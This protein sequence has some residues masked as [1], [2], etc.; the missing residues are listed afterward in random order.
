MKTMMLISTLCLV[1]ALLWAQT[2]PQI[3]ITQ[4]PYTLG[5]SYYDYLVGGYATLPLRNIPSNAGGGYFGTYHAKATLSAPR[6]V[7]ASYSSADWPMAISQPINPLAVYEGYPSLAVDPVSGKPIY[8]WHGETEGDELDVMYSMD[9]FVEG[10]SGLFSPVRTLIDNPV[11]ITHPDGTVTTDNMFLWPRSVIGPSPVAGKRR[12]YV[13]ARNQVN[14]QCHNMLFAYADFDAE[15]VENAA[16]LAW[17]YSSI[18]TL[19]AWALDAATKRGVYLAL[20]CDASGNIYLCGYHT[21]Y[22]P[23]T[24]EQVIEP[25]LD[26]FKCD[27]FGQGTWTYYSTMDRLPSWNPPASP[28]TGDGYFTDD[29]GS[30]YADDQLYWEVMNSSHLNATVDNLG[31]VHVPGLWGLKNADGG[32][33]Q[34]LQVVKEYVFDPLDNSFSIVEVFP[35]KSPDDAVNSWFQPWD[36]QAPYG[37]TDSWTQVG[38]I[39]TPDMYRDWPF[40]LYDH[41]AEHDPMFGTYNNIKITEANPSGWMAVLWQSSWRARLRRV[42]NDH[43]Y[44]AWY[45]TPEIMI[46][47]SMNN[48]YV[49]SDPVSI[50]NVDYPEFAGKVPMWSY[51]ADQIRFLGYGGGYR[52][53][54]LGIMFFDDYFWF[55]N[56]ISAALLANPGGEVMFAEIQLAE[57]VENDDLTAVPSPA[58]LTGNHPNPFSRET[59]ITYEVPKACAVTLAVYNVKGQKLR[60][61]ISGTAPEGRNSITWDAC[62]DAGRRVPSGLYFC[63]I[64]SGG[65]SQTRKMMLWK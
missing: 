50:N 39:W 59:S 56:C 34:E 22:D 19:D 46:S 12:I 60:T 18:P 16:E 6:R 25:R 43:A 51:P 7:Y 42:Y 14:R 53:G 17:S 33:Y 23:Q 10:I 49:W 30:P 11:T 52:Y 28:Q 58:L 20:A 62:D 64:S 63:R 32:Y 29:T 45:E 27:D 2:A 24:Y 31:R 40:C 44:D 48:G 9:A 3:S 47:F 55:A 57:H 15:D 1:C 37:S 26:V 54:K 41:F 35:K 5:F 8:A 61:L 4:A 65:K 36:R 38:G 21:A 13:A